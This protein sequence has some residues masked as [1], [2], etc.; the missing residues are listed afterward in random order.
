MIRHRI[1]LG[2]LGILVLS[3]CANLHA[4]REQRLEGADYHQRLALEY[5]ALAERNQQEWD[6]FDANYFA[7]KGLKA[8]QGQAVEPD[9][10]DSR[11][12]DAAA[13]PELTAARN[14]LLAL[15]TEEHRAAKP[16]EL[17][18]LQVMYDC[19]LE[20]QADAGPLTADSACR[21]AFHQAVAAFSQK[22][23]AHETTGNRFSI[24]FDFSFTTIRED[25]K[26]LIASLSERLKGVQHYLLRLTGHTDSKGNDM[27][28]EELSRV[29]AQAVQVEFMKHG[30]NK[31]Y[32]EVYGAGE[33]LNQGVAEPYQ[34]R[35][36][37]EI[38]E[39]VT[40][41]AGQSQ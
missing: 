40:P 29:R 7:G 21:A 22:P 41:P 32:I 3:G 25:G 36:D 37:I 39:N 11:T 16:A 24:F 8:A 23:K 31:D 15:H 2:M 13:L 5:L 4:L 35:V 18:R 17:A 26:A 20:E 6:W 30:V 14:D 10:L 9:T 38:Y 33:R 34:R 27:L 28:N 1:S 19:W 12:L